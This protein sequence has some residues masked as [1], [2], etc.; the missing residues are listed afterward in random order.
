MGG[1]GRENSLKQSHY[2]EA[3]TVA[4]FK[5]KWKDL[6]RGLRYTLR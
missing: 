1:Q 6:V 4:A 5:E 3:S 2:H